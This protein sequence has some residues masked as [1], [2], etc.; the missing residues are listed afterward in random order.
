MISPELEP[1]DTLRGNQPA[2]E[3][4]RASREWRAFWKSPLARFGVAGLIFLVLFTFVGPLLYHVS[5]YQPNLLYT[6]NPPSAKF[7]LGTDSLGRDYLSRMMIGGQL[8][9]EVGFA[10]AFMTTVIGVIYGLTAGLIGGALDS[11]M[12]RLVD[13]FIAIP[14]LFLLLFVDSVFRPNAVLL[15]IIIAV[16]SW[17][18]VARL[19][20]SEV[21]SLKRRDYVEAARALGASNWRIMI[22]HLLPNVM[23]VVIVNA[24]FQVADAILT[25]AA[26][27]FLGLGLPPPTPNWGEML[28]SS[29]SY[30]FQNAWWLIYPPGLAILIVELSVNFIGDALRQAFDPRLR[31][32]A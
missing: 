5:A 1:R 15:I 13:I 22:Q 18:G 24:T 4:R 31:K 10:A 3:K 7:P 32:S 19:V 25:V 29:M 20:R 16:L 2:Q 23:G 28:S 8:S 6:L 9:L 27:S 11:L 21:L 26:L 12:M 17:F 30:M 14:S